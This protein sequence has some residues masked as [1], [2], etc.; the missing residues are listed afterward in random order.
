[1]RVAGWASRS[2]SVLRIVRQLPPT[3][4]RL[5]I[6]VAVLLLGIRLLL[7]LLPLGTVRRL[8]AHPIAER[9]ADPTYAD[10][11]SRTTAALAPHLLGN[12]P[13]LVQALTVHALLRRHGQPSSLH[14]GVRKGERGRLEAH[15]WVECEGSILIGGPA[16]LVTR[17]QPLARRGSG[18]CSPWTERRRP[19]QYPDRGK[20]GSPQ[21][22]RNSSPPG[23]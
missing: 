10:R 12:A 8:L 13:C 1:M 9:P 2:R 18:E 15:A 3:D 19:G 14:I 21:R 11:V 6:E 5:G 20:T 23:R 16:A 4:R 22:P 7:F 17:F